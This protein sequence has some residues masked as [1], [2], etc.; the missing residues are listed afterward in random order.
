MIKVNELRYKNYFM[1]NGLIVQIS[2]FRT[3]SADTPL[4]RFENMGGEYGIKSL[5]PIQLTEEILLKC[6]FIH[7]NVYT[8]LVDGYK[9]YYISINGLIFYSDGTNNFKTAECNGIIIYSLHQLQN[10]YFALTGEEL[11]VKL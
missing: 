5:T 8:C 3:Y 11:T 1:H 6:W 9:E 4:V 2:G 10:I 7:K